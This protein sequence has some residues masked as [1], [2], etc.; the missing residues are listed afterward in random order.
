MTEL[1]RMPVDGPF[2]L[3]AAAGFGF[4]PNMGRSVPAGDVTMRLAFVTDDFGHQ[5][6]VVVRQDPDGGLTATPIPN[7]P[8]AVSGQ[9]DDLAETA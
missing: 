6:G 3:A 1:V 5:A 7:D 9:D 8:A 4:G 2:S